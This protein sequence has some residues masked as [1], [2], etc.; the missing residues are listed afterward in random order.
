MDYKYLLIKFV[1]SLTLCEHMG[2]VADD[3]ETVLDLLGLELEWEDLDELRE[4]LHKMGVTT[5]YG[6]ALIDDEDDEDE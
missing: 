2:D 4:K 3:I 6:T 5:L 1:A